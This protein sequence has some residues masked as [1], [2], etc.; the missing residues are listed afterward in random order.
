MTRGQKR[1]LGRI[2][3]ALALFAIGLV[4]GGDRCGGWLKAGFMLAAW[5]LAGYDVLWDAIRGI[6]RGQVF[7][8]NFLMALATVCAIAMKDWGEAAAVMIF[9]QISL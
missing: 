4:L 2:I 9:F 1:T 8:E 3:G 5:L 6:L 7:D